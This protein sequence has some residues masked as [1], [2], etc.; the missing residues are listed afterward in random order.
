M[1]RRGW[2]DKCRRGGDRKERRDRPH[3]KE[4]EKIKNEPQL[5]HPRMNC[6]H[7]KIK[8]FNIYTLYTCISVNQTNK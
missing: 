3:T 1:I 8:I 2:G 7:K 4:G 5:Q 6:G